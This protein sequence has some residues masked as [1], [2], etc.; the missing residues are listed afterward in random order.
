MRF[1]WIGAMR[2]PPYCALQVLL[3]V[4]HHDHQKRPAGGEIGADLPRSK[5]AARRRFG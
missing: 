1:A 4:S 3:H 2:L 5:D